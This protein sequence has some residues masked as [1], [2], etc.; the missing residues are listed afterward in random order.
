MNITFPA[1]TD[2]WL[3]GDLAHRPRVEIIALE[4]GATAAQLDLI[5]GSLTLDEAWSPYAQGTLTVLDPDPTDAAIGLP[6]WDP[7]RKARVRVWPAYEHPT[8]GRRESSK[9]WNLVVRR[10]DKDRVEG[11][12]TLTVSS[13]ESVIQDWQWTNAGA[14]RTLTAATTCISATLQLL[15]DYV[16][17]YVAGV[18]AVS[19]ATLGANMVLSVDQPSLWD[20]L[21]E[22]ADRAAAALVPNDYDPAS[23]KDTYELLASPT[24]PFVTGAYTLS[25]G[26]SGTVTG[27]RTVVD[28]DSDWFNTA[29]VIYTAGGTG[30]VRAAEIAA[31][32]GGS[33]SAGKKVYVERRNT[34]APAAG[35][36]RVPDAMVNRGI[37]R[38]V[39]HTVEAVAAYRVRP[40]GSV[41]LP[42]GTLVLIKRVTFDLVAGTMTLTTRSS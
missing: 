9:P 17:D 22:I 37:R 7:R 12:L 32:T 42:N 28:R 26:P 40:R 1:G 38:G 13:S 10:Y 31:G 20:L 35:D 8:L 24:A 23:G 30:P 6:V 16:P 41:Y 15:T 3:P 18:A 34:T 4:A 36:N 11:T 14:T 19:A 25:T 5:A 39:E 21:Q 29:M 27:W 2:D 33:S